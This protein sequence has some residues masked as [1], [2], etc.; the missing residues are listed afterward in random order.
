MS[1][2]GCC[3]QARDVVRGTS[4]GQAGHA[5]RTSVFVS[6]GLGTLAGPVLAL[7]HAQRVQDHAQLLDHVRVVDRKVNL[8]TAPEAGDSRHPFV[9]LL[10][11][12]V[13]SLR[14]AIVH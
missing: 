2:C 12:Q 13:L 7:L 14:Q 10:L 11:E 8:E 6:I 1:A 5:A 3:V 4:A 9:A